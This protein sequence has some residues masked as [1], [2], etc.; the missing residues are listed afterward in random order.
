[1]MA[2]RVISKALFLFGNSL[3]SFSADIIADIWR[4]REDIIIESYFLDHF[5]LRDRRCITATMFSHGFM[6]PHGSSGTVSELGSMSFDASLL[7]SAY[8][9]AA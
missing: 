4:K 3:L 9:S 1:M 6:T 2:A 8:S 5:R 7:I